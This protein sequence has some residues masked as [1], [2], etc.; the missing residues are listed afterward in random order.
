MTGALVWNL[1]H[2]AT[3]AVTDIRPSSQIGVSW[4]NKVN[5]IAAVPRIIATG[6]PAADAIR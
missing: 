5:A 4:S 3:S 2:L 6:A 1:S